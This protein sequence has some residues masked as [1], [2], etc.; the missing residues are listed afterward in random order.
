[1][2]LEKMTK[3][4]SIVAVVL[5]VI[6]I[7]S[8]AL[9]VLN[10]KDTTADNAQ[11]VTENM[12]TGVDELKVVMKQRYVFTNDITKLSDLSFM[13][14]SVSDTSAYITKLIRFE[15]KDVLGHMD[16]LALKNLTEGAD[17]F[18]SKETA[19]TMG[20]EEVPTKPGIYR[21]VLEIE[22]S[23]GNV[24]Y[25]EVFVILDIRGALINDASDIVVTVP[26]DKLLEKPVI[27][28]SIYKGYDEVDGLLSG[29]DFD[30]AFILMDEA[31]HEWKLTIS[32]TDR[33]GNKSAVDYKVTVR[34]E[35][36]QVTG[37]NSSPSNNNSGNGGNIEPSTP[38]IPSTPEPE[39]GEYDPRDVNK[40]GFVSETESMRYITPQKQKCIDAGYGVVVEQDG[41][42]WY[43]VLMK[44]GDHRIDGKKGNEILREYLK[45]KNLCPE[46]ITGCWI[47]MDNEWY[48][49]IAKGITEISESDDGK[50]NWDEI[51]WEDT[52]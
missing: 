34:E 17:S 26:V 12:T 19:L 27:D 28:E 24:S 48:W 11:N 39:N 51:E 52:D 3:T 10:G 43:A 38:T 13:I 44:E 6:L 29:V 33:A 23:S 30:Y 9:S 50:I 32:Y 25:E 35:M 4:A 1:M 7:M 31:K 18:V 40:D 20:T 16:E 46:M 42:E 45:E 15:K 21:S 8:I 2:E 5:A 37:S 22:D 14:E 49:Y 36:K 41:G 47:N